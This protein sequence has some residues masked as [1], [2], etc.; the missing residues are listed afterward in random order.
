ML[1][2]KTCTTIWQP[3]D[4][5]GIADHVSN[6]VRPKKR[7]TELM[8]KSLNEKCLN[9]VKEFRPTFF[10][11]PLKILGK[12][13]V[14]KVIL[15]INELEGVDILKQKA[16]LTERREE[17]I[18]DL[19]IPSIGYKSV[20]VDENI[21]FDYNRG[22]V[23]NNNSRGDK[24]LYVSGWLGT[25]PMGVILTTM[26]NA[27]EV[28]E[29]IILDINSENLVKEMK[30]GFEDIKPIL[31]SR[32]VQ[33]VRWQDWQKIDK[34]EQTEGSKSGKPREK[35]VDLQKMLTIAAS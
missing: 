33:V 12:D 3:E 10:R 9:K 30:G 17:L 11:S 25:G 8:L 19:V 34:F 1:K 26:S 23:K 6:L 4:F 32:N 27:F 5:S 29:K 16:V 14:E 21:P 28:A 13:K 20:Q 2:L 7:I 35:I 18:T 22:I 31:N 15:G 24:G